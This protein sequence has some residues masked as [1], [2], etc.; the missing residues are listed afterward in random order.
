MLTYKSVQSIGGNADFI[1]WFH[2]LDKMKDDIDK[3]DFDLVEGLM[4]FPQGC[5]RWWMGRGQVCLCAPQVF[6]VKLSTSSV[7]NDFL[8]LD[9]KCFLLKCKCFKN[10]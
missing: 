10:L 3:L 9:I 1:D 6:S 7:R 8:Y 5:G 4:T 2:A